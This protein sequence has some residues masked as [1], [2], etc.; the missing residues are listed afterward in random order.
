MA[1]KDIAFVKMHGLGNDFI[2]VDG[3]SDASLVEELESGRLPR[4]AWRERRDI[5]VRW[6]RSFGTARLHCIHA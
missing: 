6:A 2:V 4:E 5:D 1:D 3:L